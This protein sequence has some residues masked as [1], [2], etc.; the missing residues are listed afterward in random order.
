MARASAQPGPTFPISHVGT[1]AAVLLLLFAFPRLVQ[2]HPYAL[3]LA[4]LSFLYVILS[5]GWNIL[6]GLAGQLSF[7]HSAFF[8]LGAYTTAVLWLR[9]IH[10]YATMP[11][12]G[13]IATL[14]SLLVGLP[15]LR[16]RGPFFAI[17]T[18]GIG[19]ATRV[20]MNNLELT[21]GSSGLVLPTPE[22]YSKLPY[23]YL[24][25]FWMV[26]AVAAV[27]LILRSPFGMGLFAIRE[28]LDAAQALGVNAARYQTY[29]FMLSAF[30]AG[31][32]GS[33]FAQ[34]MFFIVPEKVF[35]F[36]LSVSMVLMPVIGG[37]AT[38]WG[39]IL[40]AL[41]FLLLQEYVL[42]SFPSLH[43]GI[44]GSLLILIILFEPG[45]AVALLRRL[46]RLRR[47]HGLA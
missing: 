46:V 21:G 41:I 3:H 29:A 31:I 26:L 7:G 20:F 24:T 27:Y 44:Y 4:I 13:V 23:Y 11:L 30:F 43:L 18:I 6:G 47:E 10:P 25:L 9:G 14:Y 16:L 39:P 45:G 2:M 28:D 17:A 36:D 32:G 12:A 1:A 19:E 40:G 15:C 8:G 38:F 33:L 37:L 35:S 42:A 22:A 5:V 34:Y